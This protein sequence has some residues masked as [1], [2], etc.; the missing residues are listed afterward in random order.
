MM[1]RWLILL[2]LLMPLS[3]QAA[4]RYDPRL[5]WETLE[6][7]HFLIHY[8]R[9]LAS[10]AG[11]LANKAERIHR[12]GSA[13]FDWT[14]RKKTHIVLS[15]RIDVA[16]G[17]ATPLPYNTIFLFATPP[18]DIDG[19]EDYDDWLRIVLQHEYTH[20][21]HTDKA[22]NFP[23]HMRKVFGRAPFFLLFPLFP[24]ILQPDWAIEGLATYRETDTRLGVG[25][26]QSSYFRALMRMEYHHGLKSL[27]EINQPLI[28]WPA[29]SARYLYG[30]Y[31]YRFLEQRYG[32]Q[33]IR[34][35][36]DD[37]SGFPVPFL[38]NL[39]GRRVLGK[40]YYQLWQEFEHDLQ[41][42]LGEEIRR[43]QA[44]GL[45][46]GEVLSHSGYRSGYSRV[47]DDGSV[48]FLRDD[49]ESVTRLARLDPQTGQQVE[50]AEVYGS[51]HFDYH[52]QAGILLPQL[53]LER[54]VNRL[55][56][57]YRL[58]PAT[59]RQQRL[60]HAGRYHTGSWGPH[61]KRLLAVH[62]QAGRYSL[63][64]LDSQ[65][66]LLEV[67]W[68][69]QAEDTVVGDIDWSPR[70]DLAVASVWRRGRGWNIELFDLRQR[71][72]RELVAT[73][74]VEGQARFDAS[75]TYIV[76]SADHDGV[77]DIYRLALDGSGQ[78]QRLT[79]VLGA[80][81]H[82]E[83]SPDGRWLYYSGLGA[84]GFDLHRI[85]LQGEPATPLPATQEPP[86]ALPPDSTPVPTRRMAYRPLSHLE[87]RW[88]LPNYLADTTQRVLSLLTAGNDPLYWHSYQLELGY[89]LKNRLPQFSLQYAYDRLTPNLRLDITHRYRFLQFGTG[90]LAY[91]NNDDRIRLSALLPY[92]QKDRRRALLAALS[93]QRESPRWRHTGLA[94]YPLRQDLLAGVVF[95]HDSS[96][97]RS[98]AV[99]RND[100]QSLELRLESSANRNGDYSGQAT[101]ADGRIFSPVWRRQIVSARLLLGLEHASMQPFELGG[102]SLFGLADNPLGKR[103]YLL[104]GYPAGLAEMRGNA[105]NLLELDW[106]FPLWL[107][108]SGIMLP[109]V[110]INRLHGRLFAE[111]GRAWSWSTTAP[112]L[113]RSVGA[114]ITSET[115][116]GFRAQVDFILGYARGL[117]RLG[118]EQL[119]LSLQLP[120]P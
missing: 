98:R 3:T 79:R 69:G 31:F 28:S 105:I 68:Q 21:L 22:S 56:D 57:L 95:S 44:R 29:G 63:H 77:Y 89:D 106:R 73:R 1:K 117:D 66:G 13:F 55:Y 23:L 88:W 51:G 39:S 32:E 92:Y 59:G 8:H 115:I 4:L 83:V 71:R 38:L 25:R 80:A 17:M 36:I 33:S 108:E 7:P 97:R 5:Q 52:P 35:L 9:D 74:S 37:Y 10:L 103:R 42:E 61:G 120:L 34:A 15:D 102:A 113:S 93:Y 87:P 46:Q 20:I 104:H 99:G 119:Y 62:H 85:A 64:L 47:A 12:Q 112:A 60:T 11:D 27:R 86:P 96:K 49:N 50:L 18:T 101:V 111:A 41:R 116:L 2:L 54:S 94:D 48:F 72:W 90:E 58:D 24:N 107:V 118:E 91:I 14:P 40:N 84:N 70:G 82:P 53:D 100:G 26:G 76:Y 75:G 30:V 67:L 110:G 19:L 114:E 81:L 45:R 109:P 6:T 65:G 43:I 78:T 16:N